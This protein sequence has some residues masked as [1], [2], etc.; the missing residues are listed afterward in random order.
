MLTIH[1]V[2][3][4]RSFLPVLC[5][6]FS[7]QTAF[8]QT[9]TGF[10]QDWRWVHF[11]VQ[12]GLP[13]NHI[14]DIAE[15]ADG[16]V[17]VAT[18]GGLAWYDGYRW[19]SIDT[20]IVPA[21]RPNSFTVDS[22][23]RLTIVV[24]TTLYQ[25]TQRGFT[26]PLLTN[27]NEAIPFGRDSLLVTAK[28]WKL[29]AYAHGRMSPFPPYEFVNAMWRTA[30]GSLWL[31]TFDALYRWERGSWL[32]KIKT[33][34]PRLKLN[35]V[36]ENEHGEG[37]ASVS[38]PYE[39]WGTWGWKRG[40]SPSMMRKNEGVLIKSATIN[41]EG[42]VIAV[43]ESGLVRRLKEGVWSKVD[44]HRREIR[45]IEF[46]RFRANRDLWVGT[47][48]G[49]FLYRSSS[50]R[51]TYL[52]H[53]SPDLR[54][55]INEIIRTRNGDV[56]IGTSKGMDV[57]KP[58]GTNE[59]IGEV[60]GDPLFVVTGLVEDREGN[61]W[62]SSGG[63]FDGAYRWDGS[64]WKR[65]AAGTP[66]EG[67]RIHKI[68]Q[69]SK[70][71]LWFLAIWPSRPIPDSL[72]TL[73]AHVY[74]HGSFTEHW[75]PHNGLPFKRV[76]AFVETRDGALWFGALGGL[77]RWKNGSWTYWRNEEHAVSLFERV[78]T[79]SADSAGGV[80]FGGT[81]YGIG[82]IDANDSV[83]VFNV[84]DGLVNNEVWEIQTD[85]SGSVWVATSGGLSRYSN[86]IWTSI[87]SRYGLLNSELWPVAPLGDKLY[88]GTR[89]SGVSILDL[90][91]DGA[92]APM[93]SIEQTATQGTTA[94]LQWKALAH[95]GDPS[96]QNIPTRFRID[97]GKWSRWSLDYSVTINDLAPG[98]HTFQVQAAGPFGS[99][100]LDVQS[101]TFAIETPLLKHP[102]VLFPSGAFLLLGLAFA[103][104]VYVR[105]RKHDAALRQSELKFRAITETT[106]SAIFIYDNTR[107]FFANYAAAA[108]TGRAATELVGRSILDIVHPDA[109]CDFV[110][111]SLA[112]RRS[113]Q[114]KLAV[115]FKLVQQ[116]GEER[117]VE[118]TEGRMEFQGRP[119]TVG[120]AVDITER[121]TAEEKNLANQEQLRQLASELSSA[122]ERERRRMATFLHDSIGQ[123]L[124]VAKIKLGS[125][126]QAASEAGLSGPLSEVRSFVE[127]SIQNTRL[128][129][130][131]LSPPTLH[132]LGL[133]ATLEW[134][135]EQMQTQHPIRITIEGEKGKAPLTDETRAL[136]FHA[137][138]EL[139]INVV[140]YASATEVRVSIRKD[141][142]NICVVVSD[143][144]VGQDLEETRLKL[145][146][147]GGFGLF[148]IRERL[149]H[150]G[151]RMGITSSPGRGTSVE[152]IAP[153]DATNE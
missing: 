146:R 4:T 79:L 93:L 74:E 39:M 86:G 1:S 134:L 98:N 72:A 47:Q 32:L 125:L 129:T 114:E 105:K 96:P 24:H 120:T 133:V 117:W 77:A 83:H 45:D 17:W 8:P 78:F 131:E 144:G 94:L 85:S 106:S 113:G 42:E 127:Q 112:Y 3:S 136:L 138:R 137:T 11:T 46:V 95:W 130:F 124:A 51:W 10:D 30:G 68:R 141:E 19:I 100:G 22:T 123:A 49:L 28:G 50:Q 66:L 145:S 75:G 107:I 13:S 108:L 126:Q 132:E 9:D 151:G 34:A 65:F 153:L 52:T 38:L 87:D 55:N 60:N 80:W 128:L 15:T 147:N 18:A 37:L 92:F 103:F 119:A 99:P 82:Y 40:R 36:L 2:M 12:S 90:A 70:G 152:L 61:V 53:E 143:N 69:D 31:N 16:M 88:V 142:K 149:T 26:P 62:A 54:N 73:G 116:S 150:L 148:N 84:A 58:D 139:L 89:G 115:E 111:K 101:A 21:G 6:F 29:Y 102:A 20:A 67:N 56:W 33:T 76:Y 104:T 71:R 121:K 135:A 81:H 118:Y 59:Y 14:Y 109:R 110:E 63:G 122:E 57:Y 25:G 140:K 5:W 97:G 41:A 64:R 48:H 43:H 44:F 91:A 35:Q 27:V 23:G 7:V